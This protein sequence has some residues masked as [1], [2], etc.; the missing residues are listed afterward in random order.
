M[1]AFLRQGKVQDTIVGLRSASDLRTQLETW[2]AR[3][4]AH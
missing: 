2:T 4:E 1:L 3:A